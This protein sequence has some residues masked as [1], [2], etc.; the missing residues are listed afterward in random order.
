MKESST[1]FSALRTVLPMALLLASC[2]GSDPQVAASNVAVPAEEAVALPVPPA[3]PTAGENPLVALCIQGEEPAD[4]CSCADAALRRDADA[5]EYAAYLH[6]IGVMQA[7]MAEGDEMDVAADVAYEQT[8]ARFGVETGRLVDTGI[9]LAG[10]FR[11][12]LEQ[13]RKPRLMDSSGDIRRIGHVSYDFRGE[14]RQWPTIA[15]TVR[16]KPRS[17]ASLKKSAMNPQIEIKAY[18][19]GAFRGE[20]FDI[21]LMYPSPTTEPDFKRP[22]RVEV[23]YRPGSVLDPLWSGRNGKASI[24]SVVPEGDGAHVKGT[25]TTELCR[26]EKN[27]APVDEASC[28]RT[29]GVIDTTLV[30]LARR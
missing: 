8:T 24:E 1:L 23:T 15:G 13:C 18:Q 7:R 10:Q 21:T 17:S 14:Q 11:G 19:S 12:K 30:T 29:G 2:S 3:S 22:A 28:F 27:S 4:A 26:K 20:T 9:E 16:D 5:Q 25:F 6:W